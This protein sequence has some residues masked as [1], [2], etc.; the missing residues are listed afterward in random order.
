[1][2][3]TTTTKL[4][5]LFE[6]G[7]QSP[8]LDN[9][10][11]SYLTS[12]KLAG[13][14]EQGIRGL[15]SNPTIFAKA[16]EDSSDYDEQFFDLIST[17][18][19]EDSYWEMAKEDISKALD[20][21]G[22]LYQSSGGSDGFVSIEVGPHLAYD[23]TGTIRAARELHGSINKPN[24][25][26]KIPATLE[27]LPAIEQ[28][29]S[30][31]I[32]INVTLIFSLERYAQVMDSYL[33]GLELYISKG[34]TPN[35]VASV[36]SVASFFVSRVDTEVDR[37]LELM[38]Q[39]NP[40]FEKGASALYGKAA[41][42]Q[43]QLAYKLFLETF[44]GERW[45]KLERAGANLQRPLWASTSTKNPNYSDLLYVNSLIGPHTVN[46]M[47]DATVEAFLDHGTI[48]RT[49]DIDFTQSQSCIDRLCEAGID[50]D[51][52]TKQLEDEGVASFTKSFDELMQVLSD[53]AGAKL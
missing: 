24:L 29:I 34:A 33:K 41:V 1:M 28:M 12:G 47:P 36:S 53:K 22:P 44:S 43:A 13:L 35:E 18:S 25:L 5:E 14:V 37:R 15:T 32:S 30:E 42:A 20:V 50:L 2:T 9:I 19:V 8:W 45:S 21:L 27:G 40:T 38:T 49:I 4:N 48:A 31:G 10:K 11:R 16:I 7:G 23:T 17:K 51:D 26:V 39:S 52:V 3:G 46:T 6:T